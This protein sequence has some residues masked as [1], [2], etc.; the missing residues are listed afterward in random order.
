MNPFNFSMTFLFPRNRLFLNALLAT[1]LCILNTSLAHSAETSQGL[2]PDHAKSAQTQ[3]LE[4][5]GQVN[6]SGVLQA[7]WVPSWP[8]GKTEQR[9]LYMRFFPDHASLDNLPNITETGRPEARPSSIQLYRHGVKADGTFDTEFPLEEAIPLLDRFFASVPAGFF[10]Y[11]EGSVAAPVRLQVRH[12]SSL[13]ECDKRFFFS[14][15]KV[16]HINPESRSTPALHTAVERAEAMADCGE[17]PPYLEYYV[18]RPDR[19]DI[20]TVALKKAP[21]DRSATIMTLNSGQSVLKLETFNDQWVRVKSQK[22][23]SFPRPTDT[24]DSVTGY[25]LRSQIMA[26][27]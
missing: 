17:W 5:A 21:D 18:I 24:A 12:L 11:K 9:S 14:D 10:R 25:V 2:L 3:R 15:F 20:L 16:L 27:N 8:D 4:Y 23:T 6:L 13:I 26:N 22:D 19:P 1:A 7:Y